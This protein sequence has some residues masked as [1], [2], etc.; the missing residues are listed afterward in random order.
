MLITVSGIDCAGKSTQIDLLRRTLEGRGLRVRTFWYRPGY[1]AELDALRRLVRRIR[2]GALPT[3]ASA[4]ERREAFARPGVSEAWIRIALMDMAFQYGVKLRALAARNDVVIC[5]RYVGD[6]LLDLELR[7]G[8]GVAERPL[9]RAARAVSA[10]PDAAFL[11]MIPRAEMI[12]RMERKR[13]PFPD[14]EIVRER[15]YAAYERL[16]AS[17]GQTVIAAD[18]PPERVLAQILEHPSLERVRR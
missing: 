17:G 13:E 16:A 2:P 4:A 12:A 7:F 15:R 8:S 9:F 3:A 11:L 6:A 14:E 10:R 18:R 1:S 5:D